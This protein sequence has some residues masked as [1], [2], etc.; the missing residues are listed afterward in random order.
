VIASLDPSI[1]PIGVHGS[2]HNMNAAYAIA[3]VRLP[4]SVH[5]SEATAK[6]LRG[7]GLIVTPQTGGDSPWLRRFA[8]PDG[9]SLGNVSGWMQV[10]GARR[11]QSLDRGFPVSDHADWDGLNRAIEATGAE[12]IGVTHGSTE[13][14]T[15]WLREK[16]VDAF[17][18][19]TR[20]VGETGEASEPEETVATSDAGVVHTSLGAPAESADTSAR[21]SREAP[22]DPPSGGGA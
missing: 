17:V 15:R 16:G 9:L 1:G 2:V 14:M 20:Y 3:G 8:G 7:V 11:W 18:V 22:D 13:V 19:P 12:R 10:R 4:V 5:A 21:E 6:E